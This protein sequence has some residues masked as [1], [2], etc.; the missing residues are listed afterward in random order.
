MEIIDAIQKSAHKYTSPDERYGYGIPNFRI[1]YGILEKE[2]LIRSYSVILGSQRLKVFPTIYSSTLNI[3]VNPSST[4]SATIAMYDNNGRLV[5][6]KLISVTTNQVQIFN[7]NKA[8]SLPSGVYF[9]RYI[10]GNE[11]QTIKVI[12]Q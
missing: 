2:R 11:N 7:L 8:P 10:D 4:G 6:K 12:K 9:L 1:A 3:L 5:E